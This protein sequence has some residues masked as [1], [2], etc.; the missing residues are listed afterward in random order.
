MVS[1]NICRMVTDAQYV[2]AAPL[3]AQRGKCPVSVKNTWI[4]EVWTFPH[5]RCASITF[6]RITAGRWWSKVRRN[7]STWSLGYKTLFL[8]ECLFASPIRDYKNS[9]NA[10][11]QGRVLGSS[12]S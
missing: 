5:G 12:D 10:R 2:L 8:K 11:S 4:H 7:S 1:S 3:T 6:E 9:G